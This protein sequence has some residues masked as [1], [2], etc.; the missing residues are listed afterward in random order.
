MNRRSFLPTALASVALGAQTQE[1][2]LNILFLLADDQRW[3][4]LGCMGDPF[5]QSPHIDRLASEGVIFQRN[6]VTTAICVSSRASIFTGLYTRCHGIWKFNDVFPEEKWKLSYPVLLKQAGYRLG[7]IG[8]FGIDGGRPPIQT[9]DYWRGFQGQ[10]HYFPL[11]DGK[12]HLTTIMGDQA[13]EFLRG[14]S[15]GQPFCLSVS[16]KAPHAQDED[17]RQF[18]YDPQDAALYREVRIP[19]PQT[20][21]PEYIR[22]LPLSVQRSEARRRWA[23]RFSTPDLYQESVKGYYR[24]ITGIDRQVGRIREELDRLGLASNTVIL[25]SSDNGFYLSEH[26]LADKWFMHEESIRTPLIIYDPRLAS[27]RRVERHGALTLNLDIAPTILDYAGMTPPASMQ[28]RSLKP[29]VEGGSP[30]W[31]KDFFYEHHYNLNGWI[32]STEGVRTSR[33]KYTIYIDEATPAEELYDL[34]VDMQEETNLA[35]DPRFTQKL[36]ELRARRETW[37]RQLKQWRP[38]VRWTDP[39]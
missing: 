19:L 24:L 7:F 36:A 10:G 26:G 18:L 22:Q 38:D 39:S 4:A 21:A 25:Y 34:E 13:I 32:P 29:L 35:Q 1:Q 23:V 30:A 12:T 8:K 11:R 9:F 31:R 28:G 15:P 20:A 27:N 3:D 17:P 5:V 14:C 37:L 33:Y 2:R 16:F 6:F